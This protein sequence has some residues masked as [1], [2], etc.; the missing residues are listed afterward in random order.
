MV[1]V[2]TCS[3]DS[4]QLYEPGIRSRDKLRLYS[5]IYDTV[6][7]N[8]T[9]YGFPSKET[10]QNWYLTVPE[11]FRFSVKLNRLFSHDQPFMVNG[12]SVQ[13]L[14]QFL[15][16]MAGLKEKLR[17]FLLQLPPALAADHDA[18]DK[19]LAFLSDTREAH[20][21]RADLAV[22]FRHPTWYG[23]TSREIL[24]DYGAVQ[25]ISSSPDKWPLV[26]VKESKANYIR[27]HG[28]HQMYHSSYSDEE[29]TSLKAWLDEAPAADSWIYF[30]NGA[31]PAAKENS[32][33]LKR[34]LGQPV[35]DQAT[36]LRMD[37]P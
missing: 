29:L 8:S 10:V 3:W 22:E 14:N 25:V 34:L 12:D 6:E 18:L 5:E 20:R 16:S 24:A 27:L 21:L 9:F 26:W 23:Q 2:G 4:P 17:W 30:D 32:Q 11:D 7:I 36:Q 15:A 19:F 35:P 37:L 1:R 28:L 33:Y 13:K 31:T